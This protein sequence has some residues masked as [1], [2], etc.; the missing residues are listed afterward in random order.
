MLFWPIGI[1]Y[2]YTHTHHVQG[3]LWYLFLTHQ[4]LIWF[5]L[6]LTEKLYNTKNSHV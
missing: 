1:V 4:C 6:G 5:N 2:K 3:K